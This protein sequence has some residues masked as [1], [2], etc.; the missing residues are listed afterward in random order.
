MKVNKKI[1][2]G[3]AIFAAA[4][5]LYLLLRR[6]SASFSTAHF[7]NLD[8]D[9]ER[10]DALLKRGTIGTVTI[11]RWPATY[12]KEI[13]YEDFRKLGVGHAMVRPNR[14]DKEHKNL[15]NLGVVGCFISTRRLLTHLSTL[16]VSDS[17]GHLILDDD[18]AIPQDILAP[19]GQWEKIRHT[20]PSDWDMIYLGIWNPTGKAINEHVIKL[21]VTDKPRANLGTFAY[22][23]RHGAIKT[24]ILPWLRYVVDAIDEQYSIKFNEWN[25]YAVTPNIIGVNEVMNEKSTINDINSTNV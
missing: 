17:T 16:Y 5:V 20:I 10:R 18:V 2:Y 4:L 21:Q 15:V 8:K 25:V 11:Q 23:V 24:K 19:D 6:P 14:L 12:G 3:L 22:I 1:L 9:T 7:M 13:P